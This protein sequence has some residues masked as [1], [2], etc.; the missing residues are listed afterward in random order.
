ME[1]NYLLTI[2]MTEFHPWGM[3]NGENRFPNVLLWPPHALHGTH[4]PHPSTQISV[5][6]CLKN[7]GHSQL[8]SAM[9][10]VVFEL[11]ERGVVTQE[12][13]CGSGFYCAGG[14]RSGR[15]VQPR[16][17]SLPLGWSL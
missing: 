1:K 2:L 5:T 16:G 10:S 9:V 12:T 8:F 3:V 15:R 4:G 6:N 14:G 13:E 17:G 11:K 7:E